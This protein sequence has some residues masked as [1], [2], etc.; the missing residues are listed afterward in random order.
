MFRSSVAQVCWQTWWPEFN[1]WDPRDGGDEPASP[2]RSLYPGCGSLAPAA[3]SMFITTTWLYSHKECVY[4]VKK[5]LKN[6]RTTSFL[7]RSVL[8]SV[9]SHSGALTSVPVY[10]SFLFWE[11]LEVKLEVNTKKKWHLKE[12]RVYFRVTLAQST[13]IDP[14][15]HTPSW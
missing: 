12:K 7:V 9:L 8:P 11:P 10:L 2:R 6:K 13:D 5:N 15:F 14:R 4:N 1:P 3:P